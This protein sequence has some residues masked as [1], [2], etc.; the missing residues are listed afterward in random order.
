MNFQND[1]LRFMDDKNV[2]FTNNQGENDLRMTKVQQKISGCFR[3]EDGAD[4]F[5]RN[6]DYL[7]TSRKMAL[8]Q[9][10]GW[11]LCLEENYPALLMRMNAYCCFRLEI[12]RYARDDSI[13]V[14]KG[15]DDGLVSGELRHEKH[16]V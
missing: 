16:R 7:T 12:P 3:S 1:V 13:G 8:A 11:S 2:P 15:I 9:L 5:C 14:R 10:K 4:I 6:R